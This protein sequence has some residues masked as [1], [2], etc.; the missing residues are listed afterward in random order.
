MPLRCSEGGFSEEILTKRDEGR[1]AE[2]GEGRMA[3]ADG[4]LRR[5]EVEFKR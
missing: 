5:G 3:P 1:A 4:W 2:S